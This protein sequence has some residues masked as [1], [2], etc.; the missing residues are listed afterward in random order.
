MWC[1]DH[2]PTIP[3]VATGTA[4]DDRI[5]G[6]VMDRV[7]G[8]RHEGGRW[9]VGQEILRHDRDSLILV[10]VTSEQTIVVL[11]SVQALSNR[12]VDVESFDPEP[13]RF[14][15]GGAHQLRANASAPVLR[16]DEESGQPRGQSAPSLNDVAPALVRGVHVML[17]QGYRADRFVPGQ[18][19]EQHRDHVQIRCVP[20]TRRP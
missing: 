16:H 11:V 7:A 20:Q 3:G 15:L 12:G 2:A 18:C 6:R 17:D 1:S 19:H 5:A 9:V 10:E 13:V 8:R 4:A 14:G